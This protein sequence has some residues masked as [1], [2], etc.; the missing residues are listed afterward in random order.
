MNWLSSN[1]I[2]ILELIDKLPEP[3]KQALVNELLSRQEINQETKNSLILNINQEDTSRKE[4]RE[5]E[6]DFAYW[7]I[8]D[9]NWVFENEYA[10]MSYDSRTYYKINKIT[11]EIQYIP[12]QFDK[13][14]IE[15]IE[16]YL[17]PVCDISNFSERKTAS[18]VQVTTP[19]KVIPY[20]GWWKIDQNNKIKIKLI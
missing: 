17:L 10:K 13:R 19:G 7:S 18:K 15:N 4:F 8:P 20:N 16:N 5:K 11:Q 6:T 14:A 12:S 9:L 1:Q 3:E 2:Y